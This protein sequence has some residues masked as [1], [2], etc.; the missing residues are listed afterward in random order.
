MQLATSPVS[1]LSE[2]SAKARRSLACGCLAAR[3][4]CTQHTAPACTGAARCAT[5]CCAPVSPA[6]AMACAHWGSARAAHAACWQHSAGGM[7]AQPAPAGRRGPAP[8]PLAAGRP[9]LRQSRDCADSTACSS[10]RSM[11]QPGPWPLHYTRGLLRC[12]PQ[13][14]AASCH[15]T[16]QIILA[17]AS[18]SQLAAQQHLLGNSSPEGSEA[19]PWLPSRLTGDSAGMAQPCWGLSWCRPVL[20]CRTSRRAADSVA[21]PALPR[22]LSCTLSGLRASTP[23]ASVQADCA[24]GLHSTNLLD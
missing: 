23:G 6:V 10:R 9:A 4:C 11:A 15:R 20:S 18:S 19:G 13:A 17:S 21:E 14:C 2:P 8:T 5:C 22:L 7:P 3:I 16:V 24:S 12:Q 1:A